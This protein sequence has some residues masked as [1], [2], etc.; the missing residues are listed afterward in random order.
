MTATATATARPPPPH[1][2][3][4]EDPELFFPV[5]DHGPAVAQVQQAK[6][7]CQRCPVIQRCLDWAL[8]TG[9]GGVLGGLDEAERRSLRQRIV[10]RDDTG[11][12]EMPASVEAGRAVS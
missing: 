10:A 12:I 1:G 8:D 4:T 11:V 2:M 6:S 5:G 7:V 3:A 9:S